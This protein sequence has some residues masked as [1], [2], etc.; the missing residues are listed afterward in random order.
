MIGEVLVNLKR[1]RESKGLS[2]ENIADSLGINQ[3]TY[4]KM[5]SGIIRL[6]LAR[7]QRIADIMNVHINYFLSQ[8]GTEKLSDE[9]ADTTSIHHFEGEEP[10]L[11]EP[12]EL[13][14]RHR[15]LTEDLIRSKDL[16]TD[17]LIKSKD[18]LIEQLQ[19][20]LRMMKEKLEQYEGK[21]KKVN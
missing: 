6:E 21:E 11:K 9:I 17:E 1:I 14:E 7:L 18:A 16:L 10:K 15:T 4:A 2:Q 20:N 5:E 12:N 3:S 19:E 8:S 13:G